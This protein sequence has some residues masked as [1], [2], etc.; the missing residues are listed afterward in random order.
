MAAA[1]FWSE[2]AVQGWGAVFACALLWFL[3]HLVHIFRRL[4]LFR[5][6]FNWR[7]TSATGPTTATGPVVTDDRHDTVHAHS[8]DTLSAVRDLFI[9]LLASSTVTWVANGIS[10][11]SMAINWVIFVLG[12][13]WILARI[14]ARGF[15]DF[16][17]LAV[18]GL[19]LIQFI[20][21]FNNRHHAYNGWW[22]ERW[23]VVRRT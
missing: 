1:T 20:L 23:N 11:E 15:A 21:A 16:I 18:M 17:S 10:Y 19:F 12:V 13:V 9:W 2:N 6:L 7:R 8:Y 5:G 14:F 3:I 22:G 4:N